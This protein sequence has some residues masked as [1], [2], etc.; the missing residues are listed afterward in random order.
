MVRETRTLITG[1]D[2]SFVQIGRTT[3]RVADFFAKNRVEGSVSVVNSR[4]DRIG[5]SLLHRMDSFVCL[6]F[7]NY[8]MYSTFFFSFFLYL[9]GLSLLVS[10]Y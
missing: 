5:E 7:Y 8:R 6:T 9:L 4:E 2:V 1:L 3:N 10:V